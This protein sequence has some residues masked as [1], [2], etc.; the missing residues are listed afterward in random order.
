MHTH[1]HRQTDSRFFVGVYLF[2]RWSFPRP[3][4]SICFNSFSRCRTT[5]IHPRHTNPVAEKSKRCGR[6]VSVRILLVLVVWWWWFGG[7][8][9]VAHFVLNQLTSLVTCVNILCFR[10]VPFGMRIQLCPPLYASAHCMSSCA[11]VSTSVT[12]RLQIDFEL[13]FGQL[14]CHF[15]VYRFFINCTWI[16]NSKLQEL[17]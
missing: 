2:S 14:K 11:R 4:I 15:R 16:V 7:A 12:L 17:N 10:F 3:L 8:V 1:T 5:H 6:R 9:S 13:D